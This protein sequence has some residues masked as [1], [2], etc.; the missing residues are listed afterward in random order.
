M[1]QWFRFR[2]KLDQLKLDQTRQFY[3]TA[4]SV[5]DCTTLPALRRHSR[6]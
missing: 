4:L 3:Q 1:V 6:N 5:I 2:V